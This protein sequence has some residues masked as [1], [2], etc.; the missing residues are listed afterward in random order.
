MIETKGS[1]PLPADQ[2]REP[3]SNTMLQL[4]VTLKNRDYQVTLTEISEGD[5]TAHVYNCQILSDQ[6]M[7]VPTDLH[8]ATVNM[9]V[10]IGQ[11]LD[12]LYKTGIDRTKL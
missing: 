9:L 1:F 4:T 2:P 10:G 3:K 7:K 5:T 11:Q 6:L 8:P 12:H